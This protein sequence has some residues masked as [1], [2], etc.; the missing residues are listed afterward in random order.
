MER[1]DEYDDLMRWMEP[2]RLIPPRTLKNYLKGAYKGKGMSKWTIHNGT[3]ARVANSEHDVD[4]S[5]G[6]PPFRR[7][8]EPGEKTPDKD[9]AGAEAPKKD[10][11]PEPPQVEDPKDKS[12]TEGVKDAPKDDKAKETTQDAPDQD[13]QSK[14]K[15]NPHWD[16]SEDIDY[17]QKRDD[18]IHDNVDYS[19]P[20]L[21][22]GEHPLDPFW[23]TLEIK[24]LLD[25]ILEVLPDVDILFNEWDEPRV[26]IDPSFDVQET[27]EMYQTKSY[28][29]AYD[30]L[31][32][33][34]CQNFDNSTY[35]QYE[36]PFAPYLSD[37][38]ESKEVCR[39]PNIGNNYGMVL[40]PNALSVTRSLVPMLSMSRISSVADLT[41][42]N[43]LYIEGLMKGEY[44]ESK[45]G[46]WGSKQNDLYWTGRTSGGL[47]NP[48][49]DWHEYHRQR[50]VATVNGLVNTSLSA[51]FQKDKDLYKIRFPAVNQCDEIQCLEMTEYFG[52]DDKPDP[53]D[54]VYK[55]R[56]QLDIDGNV[57]SRRFYSLMFSKSTVLKQTWQQEYFDEWLF[58]WVHYI[59]VS[60]VCLPP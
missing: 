3:I 25:P 23:H 2:F 22:L 47:A 43:V 9:G 57:F 44:D 29:N 54:E 42:P 48:Q 60:M 56:F 12:V 46:S 30:E 18:V 36:Y 52:I 16:I 27:F 37:L 6:F 7:K 28:R 40:S 50:F 21:P 39:H 32:E 45:D 20:E 26:L 58:P 11:L 24:Y 33:I 19:D 51:E 10:E 38:P 8:K 13:D 35:E 14:Q 1:I 4:T 41:Y 53:F 49:N 15:R 59:P 17:F 55:H 34:P 31:V 5:R